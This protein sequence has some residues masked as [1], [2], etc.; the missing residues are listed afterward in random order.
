PHMS[1]L[2]SAPLNVNPAFSGLQ[3]EASASAK[4]R[5]QW[6][7]LPNAFQTI[8][9]SGDIRFGETNNGVGLLISSDQAGDGGLTRTLA[10]GSYA[11][12]G[13]LSN[14]WSFSAGAGAGFG[15][16]Q[17][18]FDKLVFGDQITGNGY[19]TGN[20]TQEAQKDYESKAY[21]TISA[22]GMLYE[23]NFWASL[24]AFNLN[25]PNL[26]HTTTTEPL[27][28]AWILATG[29]KIY[30]EE[31]FNYKE[32]EEKSIA[33]A[34]YFY[35]QGGLQQFNMGL[36]GTYLPLQGGVVYKGISLFGETPFDQTLALLAGVTI[37]GFSVG[38][39]YDLPL[40]GIGRSI[41]GA[42]EISLVFERINYN[43]I[44]RSRVS[45]KKYR[46]VPCPVF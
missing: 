1:Q 35:S 15:M 8:Q 33:P 40:T 19:L 14:K 13:D 39:S 3:A 44:Q 34:A 24:A 4:Y 30:L 38:Y 46:P 28:P 36:Y 25:K 22:G 10:S 9:A 43:K 6:P 31:V 16:Q 29:Y 26:S 11:Y 27:Y 42:Q 23:K 21:L 20:P 7:K 12:H 41:G 17:A 2:F 37:K 32:Y 18:N 45:Y 5:R